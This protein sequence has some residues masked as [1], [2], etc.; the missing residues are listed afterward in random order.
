MQNVKQCNAMQC[1]V[2]YLAGMKGM[3]GMKRLLNNIFK[4]SDW[5]TA[6][7]NPKAF[8]KHHSFFKC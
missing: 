5:L 1:N 8:Q 3:K 4:E 7:Q 6:G 2:F